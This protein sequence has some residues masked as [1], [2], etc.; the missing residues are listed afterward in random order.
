[1][2]KPANE[3]Q[4]LISNGNFK[5]TLAERRIE[6]K[7]NR[8]KNL[9]MRENYANR[10]LRMQCA[11][12]LCL[13]LNEPFYNLEFLINKP[14]YN[15]FSIPKKSGGKRDISAPEKNLL[16]VQKK[17]NRYL[18]FIYLRLLPTNV[19]GFVLQVGNHEI[20]ANIVENAK[21]H[22]GKK[23]VLNI[24]LEDFFP[25]ITARKVKEL[26]KSTPFQFNEDLAIAIGLLTTH[27]GR[28]P[29]GAPTSPV[30]SNFIC[31][32]LDHAMQQWSIKNK[33]NYSRYADDL[34][35]SADIVF[36]PSQI[37]ELRAIIESFG[38]RVNEKKLRQRLNNRK[39]SVTGITVNTK[40]NVNRRL[41]KLVRAMLHDLRVNGLEA[42]TRNH[43]VSPENPYFD[44]KKFFLNRLEGSIAFIGQVR[45]LDDALY[46]K[47]KT[48][49][50]LLL[51]SKNTD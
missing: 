27:K 21:H 14:N 35:F 39:Q 5:Q 20:Q 42:A 43:F 24:D 40:V 36:S 8:I 37:M 22:V 30:I 34:T 18:Q 2:N 47:M 19:H 28:V 12:D 49:F 1:M 33:V 41:L 23:A 29:Q 51:H 9:Q 25:S 50:Y 48:E 46:T 38:F 16:R 15:T 44:R 7:K 26:L 6:V 13:L 45:G 3:F 10:F 4:P 17:L 31:L 32:P 11:T